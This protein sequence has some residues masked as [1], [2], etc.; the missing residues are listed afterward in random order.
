ML[1][2]INGKDLFQCTEA[3]FQEIIGNSEYAESQQLDY[4]GTFEILFADNRENRTKR[5]DEFCDDIC[6]FANTNGGY[7]VY[8]VQQ[9]GNG[10]P[11]SICGVHLKDGPDAFETHLKDWMNPIHPQ[12]PRY[13]TKLLSLSN[14]CYLI[15]ILVFS[16][17]FFP[18]LRRW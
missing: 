13:A 17:A 11:R 1:P 7:L 2:T 18:Y 10:L 15:I 14:G 8:G 12:K 3:D 4:K 5:I 9:D 6:A 16:D